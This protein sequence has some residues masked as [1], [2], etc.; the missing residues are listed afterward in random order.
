LRHAA[1]GRFWLAFAALPAGIQAVAE[2]NF[3][4]LKADPRHPSLRFKRV[5]DLWSVRA[6]ANHRAL[7]V[8]VDGG[9]LWIWIGTHAQYDRLIG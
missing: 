4:L 7:G 9:I 5:G 6:G 3:A 8:D 2:K 1:S